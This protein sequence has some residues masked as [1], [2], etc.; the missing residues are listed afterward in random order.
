MPTF[1]AG[2]LALLLLHRYIVRCLRYILNPHLLFLFARHIVHPHLLQRRRL[3]GPI[4]RFRACLHLLHVG[5]TLACN[6]LGVHSLTEARSRAGSL[7]MLHLVPTL[8]SPHLSQAAD[9][10]GLPLPAYYHLHG[11]LGLMAFLQSVV[12]MVAAVRDVSFDLNN[13]LVRFG[14][15]V[16]GLFSS[17]GWLSLTA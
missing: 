4:S 7:A 11:A 10:M 17:L 8:F 16:C 5:G 3:W 14:F 12:H 15:I 13:Q 2:C 6:V 9:Y 1:V